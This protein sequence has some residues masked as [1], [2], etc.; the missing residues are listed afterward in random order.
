M[1]LIKCPFC[2][3]VLPDYWEICVHCGLNVKAWNEM[4][5]EG[6]P[7]DNHAPGERGNSDFDDHNEDSAEESIVRVQYPDGR[8]RLINTPKWLAQELGEL[9]PRTEKPAERPAA[10]SAA[11]SKDRINARSTYEAD[12][13]AVIEGELVDYRGREGNVVV[14]DAVTAIGTEAF[15]SC[16]EM[17]SIDLPGSV[18]EIR[19]YAFDYCTGLTAVDLPDSLVKIGKGAFNSCIGLVSINIPGS[20]KEIGD[21]AFDNC[22]D[23][24]VVCPENSY[25]HRYCLE[26]H[27]RFIFDYQFEAFHGVIPPGIEKL[28]SPFQADEEKPF[29]FIS[30]SHR[31]REAVLEIIKRLYEEGWK[32]WY[33]E[34]LT[35][36][37][38]YDETLEE[39]VRDCSVF[40]LF[41]TSHSLNSRY[42]RDNEIPWA[43][44]YGKPII[45]CIL[46]EGTDYE[47]RKGTVAA[48]VTPAKIEPALEKID[49]LARGE[50]RTAEG[51]SVVV[52]PAARSEAG[53]GG[54]AGCLYAGENAATARAI[55]FE[56]RN[57]GCNLYD[58]SGPGAD[59]TRLQNCAS[60]I[61]FLDKAFLADDYLT[62]ALIEAYQ[63]GRDLAVCKLEK[64]EEKDLPPELKAL[65][66]MQW[67]DFAHG[68]NADMSAKLANHLQKRGCRNSAT[69]PGF[70]YD[71]TDEG[72]VIRKYTGMDADPRIR[73]EYGGRPVVEIGNEAFSGC[74]RLK[75]FEIP[76]SVK[77][78][79]Q[80]AFSKCPCLTSIV[81]PDSVTEIGERAFESCGDLTTVVIG[82]GVTEIAK[83]TFLRCG[84]L[85]SVT[86]RGCVKEIKEYAFCWCKSLRTIDIPEGLTRIG[87]DAFS[88]SGLV[89]ITL[90]DGL[91]RI[92][93][94]AFHECYQLTSVVIPDSVTIVGNNAFESCSRLVS[95]NIPKNLPV[96]GHATF[97]L[98]RS[99]AAVSIPDG[100]EEISTAAFAGCAMTSVVIPD[101]VAQIGDHAF[102]VCKDLSQVTIGK[103][104]R[105]IGPSAFFSCYSLAEII[106][107]DN[108]AEIGNDAFADCYD[109][110]AVKIGKGVKY[111]GKNAFENCDR[112]TVYCPRGSYTVEYCMDNDLSFTTR[113][114]I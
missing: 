110:A 87:M 57:S 83:C 77:R 81:I 60:L 67:L 69:L 99:L 44:R 18:K 55:M 102:S 36:G 56:A 96:I 46:E 70:E 21:Y 19:D 107:P 16:K 31:D 10:P 93:K 68:I 89:S 86:I 105:S 98:C 82:T 38:R 35:I 73:S 90:P 20:V 13:F 88:S 22:P 3:K 92:G 43:N 112:L 62:G 109:L 80:S 113:G 59:V 66:K 12:G 94:N 37:D 17:T 41:V 27:L 42:C 97:N 61:V 48:T 6:I 103:G 8:I 2:G 7:K 108:V 28:A 111:I 58:A 75:S 91:V 54:F 49:G 106:I 29:I 50:R 14:P 71:E 85:N 65:R 64:V 76:E 39:H 25:A 79:G 47:I 33:D 51:I 104:V 1:A 26:N 34:G 74:A 32:I 24:T 84:N 4:Q 114:V 23:L 9:P 100:V 101:S 40:L 95:V 45:K 53:G 5:E 30:Y 15:R 63:A 78:I 52:D 72:I 11:P